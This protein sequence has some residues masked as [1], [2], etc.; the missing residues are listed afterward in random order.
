LKGGTTLLWVALLGYCLEDDVE[1]GMGLTGLG[2]TTRFDLGRFS[3]F[4]SLFSS[5]FVLRIKKYVN[6]SSIFSI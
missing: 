3:F 2:L 6:F 4:L 1:D 5:S